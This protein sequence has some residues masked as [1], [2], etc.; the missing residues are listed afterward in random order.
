MHATTHTRTQVRLKR[1]LEMRGADGGPW[2]LICALPALWVGLIY[3][4][5]A[6][7]EAADLISAWSQ[8]DR[9]YLR[10]GGRAGGR[11]GAADVAG[12]SPRAGQA[13]PAGGV[14]A[15]VRRC[16]RLAAAFLPACHDASLV[17][18]AVP[19]LQPRRCCTCCCCTS[20]LHLHLWPVTLPEVPKLGLAT[21]FKGGTVRDVALKVRGAGAAM[22]SR[23]HG[24]CDG[25]DAQMAS[26]GVCSFPHARALA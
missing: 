10:T 14:V 26:Q 21:P 23:L 18:G 12:R 11:A 19:P 13:A 9:D 22:G 3:E 5:Q 2:R 7:A 25:T 8:D 15:C 16:S 6:Q 4:A 24:C 17:H 20:H 1:F